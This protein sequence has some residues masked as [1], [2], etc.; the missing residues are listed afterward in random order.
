MLSRE[1]TVAV[2]AA[3]VAGDIVRTWYTRDYTVREK[4]VDSPV[5]EADLEANACIQEMVRGAFPDDGWLSEETA[6]SADRLSA[7]QVVTANS[8]GRFRVALPAGGW[9]VYLDAPDGTQV[10]HSRIDVTGSQP[11]AVT[12][13]NR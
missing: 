9:L 2:E 13:V 11:A 7:T 4:G 3:R 6:D 12:L 5:T 8:T 1:L 10:Y